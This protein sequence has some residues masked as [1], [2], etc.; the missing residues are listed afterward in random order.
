MIHHIQLHRANI[1]QLINTHTKNI[2][3]QV[4]IIESLA[5]QGLIKHT[6][7]RTIVVIVVV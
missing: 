7:I 2:A 1:F 3:I 5:R 4:I 6:L